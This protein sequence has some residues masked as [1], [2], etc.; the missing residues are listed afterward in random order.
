[1]SK[2]KGVKGV[3]DS[4]ISKAKA[5]A[6]RATE[7]EA[8]VK[9][10]HAAAAKS[11]KEWSQSAREVLKVAHAAT[12]AHLLALAKTVRDAAPAAAASEAY[13]RHDGAVVALFQLSELAPITSSAVLLE[14]AAKL[15]QHVRKERRRLLRLRRHHKLHAVAA[16]HAVEAQQLASKAKELRRKAQA[17]RAVQAKARRANSGRMKELAL[18]LGGFERGSVDS[19]PATQ[20]N[21]QGGAKK[22][23]YDTRERGAAGV[24]AATATAAAAAAA[25]VARATPGSNGDAAQGGNTDLQ[26]SMHALAAKHT[27]EANQLAAQARALQAEAAKYRA[28]ARAHMAQHAADAPTAEGQRLPGDVLG[29]AAPLDSFTRR[30][31]DAMP[32]EGPPPTTGDAFAQ[33]SNVAYRR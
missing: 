31:F 16:S 19:F 4:T 6:T 8:Q 5:T 25:R 30:A 24:V 20:K 26:N 18:R 17:Y 1:V 13:D 28:R 22:A 21:D 2:L 27:A 10:R 11:E 29:V 14:Q 9:W 33:H 12:Q 23:R 7:A 3:A 32:L 15:F